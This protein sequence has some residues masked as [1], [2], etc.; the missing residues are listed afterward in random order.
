M[1]LLK[2]GV[3]TMRTYAV[4]LKQ[5]QEPVGLFF[6]HISLQG[7]IEFDQNG[8]RQNTLVQITQLRLT[9]EGERK[10]GKNDA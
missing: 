2:Y 7:V 9:N 8:D 5:I 6:A 1:D 4:I 10:K 3:S